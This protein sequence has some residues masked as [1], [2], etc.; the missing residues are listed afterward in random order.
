MKPLLT[1]RNQIEDS[2]ERKTNMSIYPYCVFACIHG[3]NPLQIQKLFFPWKRN[4]CGYMYDSTVHACHGNCKWQRVEVRVWMNCQCMQEFLLQTT[5]CNMGKFYSPRLNHWSLTFGCY[6]QIANCRHSA[7][8]SRLLGSVASRPKAF[9]SVKNSCI[10]CEICSP[11]LQHH[12]SSIV[13]RDDLPEFLDHTCPIPYFF[14]PLTL[15]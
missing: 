10:D 12:I 2:Q 11:M 7:S 1:E 6:F 13:F 14:S 4:A 15:L 9:V 3:S 5:G 8:A